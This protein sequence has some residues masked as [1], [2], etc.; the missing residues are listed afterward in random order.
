MKRVIL[1]VLIMITVGAAAQT[2]RLYTTN[3]KLSSSIV[4]Q[5]F[6]DQKGR[7]WIPTLNGLNVYDGYSFRTFKRSLGL[8]NNSVNW[9]MQTRTG[10]IY[11]G[12]SNAL[13]RYERSTFVDV[14]MYDRTGKKVAAF[15]NHIIERQNGE[16]MVSTSG[17][18]IYRVDP[19]H[20]AAHQ[21]DGPYAD[22][23]YSHRLAEDK[24]QRIWVLTED[25]GVFLFKGASRQQYMHH[26]EMK[27]QFSSICV[28]GSDRV[29]IG[30]DHTGLYRFVPHSKEGFRQIPTTTGLHIATITLKRDGNLFLGCDGQG[31]IQYDTKT[32]KVEPLSYTSTDIDL[33]K[34]KAVSIMEDKN[35]NIWI[36]LLQKGVYMQSMRP[37]NFRY[38]GRKSGQ[39]NTIGDACV[40]CVNKTRDGFLWVA[41]DNDGLYAIPEEG[42]PNVRHYRLEVSGEPPVTVLGMAEDSQGRLWVGTYR[43]GCGWV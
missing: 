5:V 14:P 23:K 1:F 31:V 16:I 29:F 20:K 19:D 24:G 30:N 8:A 17:Y 38:L 25:S 36:G 12:M 18:G 3:D 33:N 26:G 4:S 35:G 37:N 28:D 9:V 7:I 43:N 10:D 34:S 27:R 21:L 6:Q 40:M 11:I 13:Q 39:Y 2:G 22:I 15:V 42:S 32:G 41:G